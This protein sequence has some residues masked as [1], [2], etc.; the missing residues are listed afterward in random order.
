[1]HQ[2]GRAVHQNAPRHFCIKIC[3]WALRLE[4]RLLAG[5]FFAW[6]TINQA[7]LWRKTGSVSCY[8]DPIGTQVLIRYLRSFS[9]CRKWLNTRLFSDFA[10]KI[11]FVVSKLNPKSRIIETQTYPFLSPSNHNETFLKRFDSS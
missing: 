9:L 6:L 10:N 2:N 3:D 4:A 1:M 11:T 5:S 8:F 7:K